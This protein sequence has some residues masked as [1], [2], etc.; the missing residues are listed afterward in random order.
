MPERDGYTAGT[1]SWVDLTT[2][3][4]EGAKRFYGELFGWDAEPA[5]D[6]EFTGGHAIFRGRGRGGG[7]GGPVMA[8][9]NP[10]SWPTS[11]ATDAPDALAERVKA[12]G[13]TVLL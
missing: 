3:D 4:V 8:G 9:G 12:A 6:P 13:G 2:P 5:G 1:P 7:G 11:S 10:S